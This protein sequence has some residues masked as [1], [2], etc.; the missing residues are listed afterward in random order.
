M[1]INTGNLYLSHLGDF[2]IGTITKVDIAEV[3]EPIWIEKMKQPR[4]IRG[5][6]ETILIMLRLWDILRVTTLLNGKVILNLY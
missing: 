1:V 2:I 4:R 3:L 5:R 6:I